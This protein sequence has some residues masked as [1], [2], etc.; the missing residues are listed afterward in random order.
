VV[1]A[2]EL[3]ENYRSAFVHADLTALVNCFDFPLQVASVYDF[4]AVYTLVRIY[5]TA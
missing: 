5:A 3:I 1:L 2:S 4:T